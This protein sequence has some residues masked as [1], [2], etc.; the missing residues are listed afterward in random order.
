MEDNAQNNQ[1]MDSWEEGTGDKSSNISSALDIIEFILSTDTQEGTV[2]GNEINTG[3]TKLSTTIYRPEYTATEAGKEDS[4][5]VNKSRQSWTPY[6]RATETKNRN[7]NQEIVQGRDRGRSSSDSGVETMV[8]G[9]IPR[10]SSDP[11]DG[12]QIQEDPDYNEVR[13]MDKNTSERK[14]RQPENVPVEIPRSDAVPPTE[15]NGNSDDGRSLESISTSNPRYTGIVTTATLDDEEELLMKNKKPKKYQSILQRDDKEIK[16]GG[17]RQIETAT[18][19]SILDQ[20]LA[21]RESKKNQTI[22]KPNTNTKESAGPQGGHR[23][24]RITSWDIRNNEGNSRAEQTTKSPNKSTQGPNNTAG[25]SRPAPEPWIKAQKTNGEEKEDTEESTRFTERAITLLQ[26]LGV[27]QFAAKLD[28]YQDKRVVC[29]ANVLNNADT[30]SKIDFLAGL[31]IGVSMDHD[32]KLNQIQSEILSL[33]NDLK[34]MDESHR[35]LIENQ[36]EQLSLITS[37]ISNLKIMT[38]RGGKKDQTESS[39]RTSMIT[40]KAKE[41][42]V[43]K[44]RFDPLMETQGIGKNIPDLYRPMEKTPENDAQIRSEMSRLDDESNATRLVP[45]RISSTMRSLIIIINNSN[46]SSKAKQ[47]YINELKLCKNDEEVSE[48]MDMFNEDISST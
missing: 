23:G 38:E 44:V 30:A 25:P 40:T 11:N 41:E 31:M 48:L 29:V 28:L 43:K 34:K 39:G 33:K 24:R 4:G 2:D 10:G 14:M 1:I 15:S 21:F 13:K 35:R 27:I 3:S 12:T 9:G 18:Q 8:S 32:N 20:G 6:E 36:K 16:K 46:L 37:L 45:R 5:S 47:S 26:N 19:P 42:K 7:V 22:I 17:G